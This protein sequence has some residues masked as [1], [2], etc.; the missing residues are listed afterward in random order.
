MHGILRVVFGAALHHLLDLTVA[1]KSRWENY[2][3]YLYLQNKF[4][5]RLLLF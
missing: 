4:V 3:R 5:L 1:Q 2:A